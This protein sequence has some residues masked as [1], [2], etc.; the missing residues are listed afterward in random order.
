MKRS[1]FLPIIVKTVTFLTRRQNQKK[2]LQKYD[3]RKNIKGEKR[4]I[5]GSNGPHYGNI[6]IT[7]KS[8]M[9]YKYGL[10][11]MVRVA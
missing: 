2:L 11:V 6:E 10:I 5:S 7:L 8:N 3:L 1:K 4:K 9:Y